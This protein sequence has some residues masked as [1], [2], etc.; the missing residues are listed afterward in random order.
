MECKCRYNGWGFSVTE[1]SLMLTRD[2]PDGYWRTTRKRIPLT[3]HLRARL[4]EIENEWPANDARRTY[5]V[6]IA[7]GIY[8][9]EES[10]D[11]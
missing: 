2:Y 7:A 11:E 4:N 8:E 9:P 1:K 6:L 3:A 5:C 10:I